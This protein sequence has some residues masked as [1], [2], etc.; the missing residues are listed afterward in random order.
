MDLQT[1]EYGNHYLEFERPQNEPIRFT[2]VPNRD[3]A[4]QDVIRIQAI[5]SDGNPRHGPEIPVGQ[6]GDFVS[7]L[8]NLLNSQA[9]EKG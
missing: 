8:I 1:D 2:Y 4:G 3:W 9:Q 5:S 7:C 6:L